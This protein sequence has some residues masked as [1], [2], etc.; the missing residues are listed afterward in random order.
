MTDII[1]K[2]RH[3]NAG[4]GIG[5]ALICQEAANEIEKLRAKIDMLEGG[6]DAMVDELKS[7]QSTVL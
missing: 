7:Y 4:W 6:W 2:L 5:P 1:E 3:D